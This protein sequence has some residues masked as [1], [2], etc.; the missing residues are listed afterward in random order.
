MKLDKK[1]IGKQSMKRKIRT[2]QVGRKKRQKL[3]LNLYIH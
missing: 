1:N 2:K 3:R